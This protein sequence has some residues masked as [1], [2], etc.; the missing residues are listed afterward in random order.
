MDALSVHFLTVRVANA[1]PCERL[2][3]LR[4]WRVEQLDLEPSDPELAERFRFRIEQRFFAEY[5]RLLDENRNVETLL[6]RKLAAGIRRQIFEQ[7]G[8][9][10]L[11]AYSIMPNHVHVVLC[12]REPADDESSAAR[13]CQVE[14]L[15][16]RMDEQPDVRSP[17]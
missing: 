9:Y 11:L 7:Q 2:H 5:D 16:H 15:P 10:Q 4:T 6:D 3:E 12:T 14:P 17:L 8:C 1:I 13:H